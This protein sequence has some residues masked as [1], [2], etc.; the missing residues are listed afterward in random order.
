MLGKAWIEMPEVS[1][2]EIASHDL[3]MKKTQRRMEERLQRI[4]TEEAD[5]P[6]DGMFPVDAQWALEWDEVQEDS[7]AVRCLRE[8]PD[9]WISGRS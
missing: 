8:N 1:V 5:P 3:T 2:D 6:A 4:V 7:E 9:E